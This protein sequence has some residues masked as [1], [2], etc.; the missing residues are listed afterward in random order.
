[1]H[2]HDPAQYVCFCQDHLAAFS[3]R[4]GKQYT[5]EE[6]SEAVLRPGPFFVR[7][8]ANVLPIRRDGQDFL[9]LSVA[10]LSPDTLSELDLVLGGVNTQ[11]DHWQL[12]RLSKNGQF[13]E[14]ELVISKQSSEDRRSDQLGGPGQDGSNPR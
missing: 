3:K 13:K 6:L 1:M 14:V 9:L 5:R 7:G 4:M 8:T 10:N 2:N 11:T 12:S